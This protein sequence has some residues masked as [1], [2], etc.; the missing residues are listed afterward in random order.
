MSCQRKG[1]F[2]Q[3][4]VELFFNIAE[5]LNYGNKTRQVYQK[6]RSHRLYD[7]IP[8]RNGKNTLLTNTVCYLCMKVESKLSNGLKTPGRVF[9][10]RAINR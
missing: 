2:Y 8:V 3:L 1:L 10:K 5:V 9:F 6:M 7:T 4:K